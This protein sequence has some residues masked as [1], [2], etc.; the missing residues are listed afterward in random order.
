MRH[1]LSMRHEPA[2]A[3]ICRWAG[4]AGNMNRLWKKLGRPAYHR[5]VRIRHRARRE[6]GLA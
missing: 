4:D 6:A 5:V 1:D 3:I 2:A